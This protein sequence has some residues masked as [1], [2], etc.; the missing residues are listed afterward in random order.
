MLSRWLILVPLVTA[1][2]LIT[3]C[4]G[5]DSRTRTSARAPDKPPVSN[6]PWNRPQSWEGGGALGAMGMGGR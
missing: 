2:F 5:D 4:G 3:G 1:A 6:L